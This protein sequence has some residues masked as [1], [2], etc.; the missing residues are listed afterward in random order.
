MFQPI[1][2]PEAGDLVRIT[3]DDVPRSVRAGI[4]LALALL[5]AQVV[6]IRHSPVSGAPRA[7]L[8]LMGTCFECMVQLDGQPNVR[9]CMVATRAGM[10]VRLQ[11][12]A[13]AAAEVSQ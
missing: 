13:P 7:P 5:E 1:D 9:S 6:P 12:G 3:V 4:P 11:H 2:P 8:C 10:Q